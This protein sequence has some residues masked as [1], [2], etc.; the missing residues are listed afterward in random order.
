MSGFF[1]CAGTKL[2][3]R[4]KV[5]F[6]CSYVFKDYTTDTKRRVLNFFLYD[7]VPPPPCDTQCTLLML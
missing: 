7:A 1:R 6:V 4:L 3:F 2:L 5:K